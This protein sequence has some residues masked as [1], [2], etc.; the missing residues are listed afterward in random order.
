MYAPLWCVHFYFYANLYALLRLTFEI[1]NVLNFILVCILDL[2]VD[3]NRDS[4]LRSGNEMCM[5]M[6]HP[7]GG[8]PLQSVRRRVVFLSVANENKHGVVSL[9]KITMYEDPGKTFH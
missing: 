9:L 4:P 3:R 8:D 6:A 2:S 1:P 7:S 5:P